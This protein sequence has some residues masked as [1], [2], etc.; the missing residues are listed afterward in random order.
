MNELRF[1]FDTGVIVSALLFEKSPPGDAFYAASDC[2]EVLFSRATFVELTEVLQRT[3]FDRYLTREDR[4]Q[5]L[6][7]LLAE[8]MLLEP[9]DAFHACR[10]AKDDKFLELAVS[11]RASCLITGDNDL[12]ILHPFRGIPILSPAQFLDWLRNVTAQRDP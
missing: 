5:F 12:L 9:T 2:G 11:G 7:A 10:D 4:D 8:A 6:S 1:V 3:K